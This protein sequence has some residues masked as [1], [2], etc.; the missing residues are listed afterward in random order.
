MTFGAK[1]EIGF[2]IFK[3]SDNS[4]WNSI[5]QKMAGNLYQRNFYLQNVCNFCC[6]CKSHT[7]KSSS[8]KSIVKGRGWG[9]DSLLVV[10]LIGSLIVSLRSGK[11]K[12]AS[13]KFTNIR[14]ENDK[15]Q[16]FHDKEN[17]PK[18]AQ[19]ATKVELQMSSKIS[20]Y[21]QFAISEK[22]SLWL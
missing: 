3:S 21:S 2:I 13:G 11:R 12:E 5:S 17:L 16:H 6:C 15:I 10:S 1:R 14:N 9:G 8:F 18:S 20:F 4:Y 7:N 22:L 19:I